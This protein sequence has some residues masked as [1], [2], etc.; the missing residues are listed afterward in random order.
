MGFGTKWQPRRL[1]ALAAEVQVAPGRRYQRRQAEELFL[2]KEPFAQVWLNVSQS[3][4][5]LVCVPLLALP[6]K[7]PLSAISASP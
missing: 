7:P 6:L 4:F 1:E 3:I 5:T 2:P